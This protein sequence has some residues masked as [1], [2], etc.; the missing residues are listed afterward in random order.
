MVV[1]NAETKKIRDQIALLNRAIQG[2]KSKLKSLT[3]AYNDIT[4]KKDDIQKIK[5]NEQVKED[6]RQSDI[7]SKIEFE[8]VD[9]I[10]DSLWAEDIGGMFFSLVNITMIGVIIVSAYLWFKLDKYEK[11][12]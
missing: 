12:Y 1:E 9:E 11:G 7:R 5:A 4:K 2:L 3:V 10:F 6:F 8:P